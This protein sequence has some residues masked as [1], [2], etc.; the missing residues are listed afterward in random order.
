MRRLIVIAALLISTACNAES[1]KLDGSSV[2][3]FKASA[4]KIAEGLSD[5]K[6]EAL[7][8]AV[9]MVMLA[10]VPLAD[11]MVAGAMGEEGGEKL[12]GQYVNSLNGMTAE[13]VVKKAQEM[14]DSKLSK[15]TTDAESYNTIQKELN[16]VT[17]SDVS[18]SKSKDSLNME[19]VTVKLT[20]KNELNQAI[21]AVY[22]SGTVTTE[23]RSTP[24]I[25]EEINYSIPGGIEPNETKKLELEPN[26]FTW[27][28]DKLPANAKLELALT[29]VDDAKG[30]PLLKLPDTKEAKEIATLQKRADLFKK[31]F[32]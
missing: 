24:W 30:E 18:I 31:F 14:N 20:V 3:A 9:T 12:A 8:E 19:K 7:S 4:Q 11:L 16:K 17:I 5:E 25:K 27:S 2:T 28:G 6:R 29:Q 10:N 15:V 32:E 26:M 1:L 22:F 21:S 13:E 23:G